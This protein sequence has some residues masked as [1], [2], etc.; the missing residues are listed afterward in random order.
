M[1]KTLFPGSNLVGCEFA[2]GDKDI[3][4][5]GAF[6]CRSVRGIKKAAP[7]LGRVFAVSFS[8]VQCDRTR[9]SFQLILDLTQAGGR[10]QQ[11]GKPSNER[12]YLPIN[13]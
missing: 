2:A 3:K 7:I 6:E 8:N 1:L 5:G 12:D 10:F 9:G 11:F 13:F 4:A